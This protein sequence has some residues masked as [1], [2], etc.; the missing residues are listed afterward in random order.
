MP[1]NTLATATLFQQQL[2][3]QMIQEAT[4]GWMES[5]AG[6]VKYSGGKEIKI[7]KLNMN[8][9]A[10]YDRDNGYVQGAVTLEYETETMTQDRGRKFQLDSMD[11]DETSFIAS[12]ANVVTQFQRLQIIPEV[13]AYRYSKLA[14]LAKLNAPAYGY[15]ISR[16][17]AAR[18]AIEAELDKLAA[19]E[20]KAGSRQLVK[21]Y[22]DS[23]YK[24]MYDALP[25]LPGTP[26]V[27]LSQEVVQQ[28]IQNPWKGENYSSRV[29]KNRDVLASEGGKMIDAGVTAGK[30]IQQM[31]AE[32]SDLMDVGSY[33]AARLIRTEVNR[34][35]NDAA[36]ESYKAMGVKEY[37]YL[38]TLDARTCA[39]CGAL[40]L[41]VFKVAE[42]K[43]GVNFPPMHPNDRCTI[44]PVIPGTEPDGERTARN[45]ETGKNY[46]VPAD[47]TY[48]KWRKSISEK[49]GADSIQTAQ[50]KYWNRKT[51]IEQMKAI[52]KVLGKDAPNNI[53]DFQNLK[54]NK[55]DKWE[56]VKVQTTYLTENPQ[57]N[58]IYYRV[59]EKL[60]EMRETK[61]IRAKGV[62][63]SPNI[64]L[65][66]KTAND[67]T[68]M[69]FKDRNL[70]M[71]DAQDFYKN[72][73]VALKQRQ[74][75]QYQ[76][77]SSRGFVAVNTMGEI[78]SIGLL[79]MA[80]QRLVEEVIKIVGHED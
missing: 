19:Q 44:A 11:V 27:P 53:A 6:Q 43:T 15:R 38:A 56:K 1:I 33:V 72:A 28:A 4:S 58:L 24:T 46:T 14:A 52:R 9:L 69:R 60:N 10:N 45:P 42:A 62:A 47:M 13:D 77:Y 59:N 78:Q 3:Q 49:Y 2:D 66:I 30:S 41:K 40:D 68:L 12:A 25:E 55:P 75:Q 20:E 21:A 23:Y 35:H 39:V 31:T 64:P 54:Y 36:L 65:E 34:M 80:G 7:P 70:S 22:D 79:D 61:Q 71:K 73:L 17:Q 51:D 74:G 32:L 8:G 5:N 29:W 50:K 16:L 48:E 63:V 18:R 76:F 26:V 57:S 67:H 37:T